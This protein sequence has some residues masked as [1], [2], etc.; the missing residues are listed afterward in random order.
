R[1]GRNGGGLAF[2]KDGFLYV[3]TSD[4]GLVNDPAKKASTDKTTLAGKILRIDVNRREAGKPYG[5]PTDNP[6][7]SAATKAL[8]RPEIFAWGVGSPARFAVNEADGRI[9]SVERTEGATLEINV[10]AKGA[11]YAWGIKDAPRI[12]DPAAL[13]K[14]TAAGE[15]VVDPIVELAQ[16]LDLPLAGGVFVSESDP[17]LAPWKGRYAY[18]DPASGDVIV[19]EPKA[20][21]GANPEFSRTLVARTGGH[22]STLANGPAGELFALDQAAGVTWRIAPP[23]EGAPKAP[24]KPVILFLG[25]DGVGTRESGSRYYASIGA[26]P[27][28]TL[29]Q[30]EN[31]HLGPASNRV[32]SYYQNVG[33]LGFF[34]DMTCSKTIAAGKGG[35]AVTNWKTAE[36]RLRF[37]QGDKSV[38]NLGTVC[39]NVAPEGYAGSTSS[40]TTRAHAGRRPRLRGREGGPRALHAVPRR[41]VRRVEGTRHERALPRVR[42]VVA[43]DHPRQAPGDPG[44][45][46]VR[47]EP[48]HEDGEPSPQDERPRRGRRVPQGARLHRRDVSERSTGRRADR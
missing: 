44:E 28:L 12:K 32:F 3:G 1:V 43:P 2:G 30:W 13:A 9:F 22:V 37:L 35:C 11:N 41:K 34:R 29:E 47:T 46:V 27:T 36:D 6:F 39:M 14:L 20:G 7:A 10:I 16:P 24:Y 15:T 8:G 48:D 17:A 23:P 33:D 45:R 21:S 18:G 26:K 42:A 19:L 4:G 38:R 25:Q 31:E 5:I 40:T